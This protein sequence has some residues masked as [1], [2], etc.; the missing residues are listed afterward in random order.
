[1]TFT[2]PYIEADNHFEG[3]NQTIGDKPIMS[4]AYAATTPSIL[5][6]RKGLL[7]VQIPEGSADKKVHLWISVAKTVNTFEWCEVHTL[8]NIL[9]DD[10]VRTNQDNSF[11]TVG[12][13]I[14]DN[15]IMSIIDGGVNGVPNGVTSDFDGQV[16]FSYKGVGTADAQGAI[17][18]AKGNQWL[19][20]AGG[21]NIDETNLAKLDE[22]NLFTQPQRIGSASGSASFTSGRRTALDPLAA[23]TPDIVPFASGDVLV[24]D[25]IEGGTAKEE[26]Y[27]AS[28]QGDAESWIKVYDSDLSVTSLESRVTLLETSDDVTDG[29]LTAINS[30]LVQVNLDIDA[31]QA[32]ILSFDNDLALQSTKVD[33]IDTR[34]RDNEQK[35]AALETHHN[36]E[37]STVKATVNGHANSIRIINTTM[38]DT[39]T[40][41]SSQGD[42]ITSVEGEVRALKTK[43]N[44]HTSEISDL[45]TLT[46]TQASTIQA[47]QTELNALKTTVESFRSWKLKVGN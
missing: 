31:A 28:Q 22:T 14:G 13:T 46:T 44:T 7:Y 36:T 23:S 42:K 10:L 43:S 39:Q 45:K 17:W 12:Q 27:I 4:V 18:V 19:P 5:P 33:L 3:L 32:D 2:I 35:I 6:D 24:R 20:V 47:L 37:F 21:G 30:T 41:I 16:Y 15:Q 25:F 34:V 26:V 38:D 8:S 29:K 11:N 40:T 9:P 1:M